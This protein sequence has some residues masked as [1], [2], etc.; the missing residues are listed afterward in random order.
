MAVVLALA[1]LALVIAMSAT[2]PPWNSRPVIAERA[3]T[4]ARGPRSR[5]AAVTHS[6]MPGHRTVA[7]LQAAGRRKV[8]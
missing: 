8:G 2:P 4:V 6:L 1:I 7:W 3:P 5:D